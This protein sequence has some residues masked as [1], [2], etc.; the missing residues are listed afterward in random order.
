MQ[1]TNERASTR[2][3]AARQHLVIFRRSIEEKACYFVGL[4]REYG[5]TDDEIVAAS[6]L[7][8]ASVEHLLG[9]VV[10]DEG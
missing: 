1:S 2:K 8:S 10:V 6:G 3:E 4:G 7:S 5:L 9:G